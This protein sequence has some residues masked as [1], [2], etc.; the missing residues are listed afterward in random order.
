MNKIKPP[1]VTFH[2]LRAL[3]A[4][5]RQGSVTRAAR[6]LHLTQPTVSAQMQELQSTLDVSLFEPAGRG[7]KPT[8]SAVLLRQAAL[9]M[10]ARWQQFEDDLQ[11]LHGL[12]W[13]VLRIAGVSTTEYFIA[14]WLGDFTAAHPGIEIDLA[15]ENRDAV[16]E[17]LAQERF[18]LAVMMMPPKHLLL[19]H[20]R[21]M[22]NP[23][24][25]VGPVHHPWVQSKRAR[26]PARLP[27][28]A[29]NGQ[30]LLMREVGS[31]T[32]LATEDYLAIHALS[33]VIRATLGSNEAIKHAVAAG[34]GLAVLSRHALSTDPAADGLAVLPVTGFPINRQWLLV[35]RKDRRLSLAA[36]RFIEEVKGQYA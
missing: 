10:F 24:V 29:I 5:V 2:Q 8:E 3:E 27:R 15:V 28:Q 9:E 12:E 19:D 18:E 35:W 34:L 25:L 11:A 16:V 1:R 32:R 6:E 30:P 21:V 7:I 36:R 20:V 13:G 14:Q 17:H 23:L 26:Q 33:P 22:Q 4:V 31:G